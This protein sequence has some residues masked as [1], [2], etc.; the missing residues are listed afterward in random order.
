MDRCE[1]LRQQDAKELTPHMESLKNCFVNLEQDKTL[2]DHGTPIFYSYTGNGIDSDAIYGEAALP[3]EYF[4]KAFNRQ[5]S[6][7]GFEKEDDH[8]HLDQV[9]I[10]IRK[11]MK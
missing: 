7:I 11:H 4:S 6:Y 3:P 8:R 9:T 2:Y 5:F 1:S 10:A